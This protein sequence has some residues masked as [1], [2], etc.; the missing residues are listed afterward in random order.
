M[1]T[2][3]DVAPGTVVIQDVDEL[4]VEASSQALCTGL[5]A[6]ITFPLPAQRRGH[7]WTDF[8]L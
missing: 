8:C 4:W 6:A 7:F 1:T 3:C 2:G 5:Q